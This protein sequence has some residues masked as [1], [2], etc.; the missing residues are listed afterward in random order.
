MNL[1]DNTV[2][3]EK[4]TIHMRAQSSRDSKELEDS[5]TR[6]KHILDAKF[7]KVNLKSIAEECS[8][9]NNQEKLCLEM[10]LQ[11]L[12]DGTSGTWSG[13]PYRIE[14]KPDVKPYHARPF[15]VPT[16]HEQHY[17]AR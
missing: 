4:S 6:M 9:L 12:F 11:P 1:K 2:T 5:A 3:W 10:L 14:L 17:L 15:P 16:I 7:K 8:H 13:K